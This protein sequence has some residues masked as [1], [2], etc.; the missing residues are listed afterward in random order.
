MARNIR[1]EDFDRQQAGL[2]IL[3]LFQALSYLVMFVAGIILGLLSSSH[4]NQYFMSQAELFLSTNHILS[5]PSGGPSN[6]T[7]VE[8]EKSDDCISMEQF[9]F[10][11]KLSHSMS[12][13]ELLWRASMVPRKQEWPYKRVPKV[14]FMFLTR[15]PLPMLP[16]WERFFH[17]QKKNLYTIYVHA[18]PGYDLN[19][20]RDSVFF[21]RQI[22]SQDVKWGTVT[23]TDAERRLLS[24][25]LLDFSNE[26]FVLLSE[27][28][29]PVYNFP[30]V[31]EYLTS[32]DHS[33]VDMYDDPS[34]DGRGRYSTHML[35]YIT[36]RQWRKGSQWFEMD[37][38]LATDIVADTKYYALFR[39]YCKPACYPDEHFIPTYLNIFHGSKSANR[40]VTYV[41][42]SHGGPH[43]ARFEAEN[44]TESFIRSI[45][46]N[47]T[48][49]SYN[50]DVSSLCYLFARKFAPSTL[51]PLLNLTSSV[52]EF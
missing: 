24:N 27:S 31:Y 38:D 36:L 35:P 34:R 43:P 26:R 6:C 23:L 1:A 29:I 51:E 32:S 25:A 52:M 49:C 5:T 18:L 42:W 4:I 13:D 19:V 9:L 44:I 7:I 30:T 40:S 10:P 28:C 16:L 21:G 22:P 15:G 17:G 33:F 39:K 37:R 20:S 50:S 8:M 41:D 48:L 45:R 3:R 2:T 12:D 14:A 11:K 46:N 47:G